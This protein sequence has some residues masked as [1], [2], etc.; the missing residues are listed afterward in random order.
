VCFVGIAEKEYTTIVH[1]IDPHE[2]MIQKQA[3]K[4]EKEAKE[5]EKDSKDPKTGSGEKD[6]DE[7]S[8]SGDPDEPKPEVKSFIYHP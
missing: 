8:K 5:D 1:S 3:E 2:T 7:N 4:E 6:A